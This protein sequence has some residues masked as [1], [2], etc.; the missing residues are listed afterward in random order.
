M[1]D[2][3]PGQKI[4]MTSI[5]ELLCVPETSGT[6]EICVRDIYPFENHPFKVLDDEKMEEL[7]ES[8]KE[9]G[10]LTPVIVRKDRD[11]LYQMISGHRRLYASKKA[12]LETIPAIIKEMDDDEAIIYMVD[13]NL[14]REEILP[15]EKAFSYKMKYDAM[16]RV[17][18]RPKKGNRNSAQ[19]G[20]NLETADI[21]GIQVG[22]SR[23]QVKRYLRLTELITELLDLVDEKR[24]P[25]VVGVEMSFFTRKIQ[26]WI[27]E[28]C[29]DTR[30]PK[31]NELNELR[32]SVPQKDITQENLCAYLNGKKGIPD[33]PGKIVLT[34]RKLNQ[35]F[36]KYMS[37]PERE[38]II[39]SLLE[40]WKEEQEA[41][42]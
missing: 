28:Y 5:D 33:P 37:T 23:N 4:K 24:I 31:W 15:S 7:I 21:L 12:G 39:V 26:G 38:R 1:A 22:E 19:V 29:I 35:Y 10:I 20:R 27:H 9:Y 6:M 25:I 41:S 14:Q 18:G 32:N 13:S 30:I 8:I 2:K 16:K 3:R 17:A 42:K 40:K 36:P 11:D 34:Q